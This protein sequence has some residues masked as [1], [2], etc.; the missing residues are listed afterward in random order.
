MRDPLRRY[1]ESRTVRLSTA[2]CALKFAPSADGSGGAAVVR[3]QVTIDGVAGQ[4]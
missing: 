4:P 1:S 3:K 2:D